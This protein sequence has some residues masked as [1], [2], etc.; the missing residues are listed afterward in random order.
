MRPVLIKRILWMVPTILC[1]SI[2]SFAL[3]RIGGDPIDAYIGEET[4]PAAIE[5]IVEQYHFDAPLPVQYWY[6]FT[7][8]LQ[9]DWG[10]SRSTGGLPVL[11]AIAAYLPASVELAAFSML[12][13][14]AL[15]LPLGIVSATRSNGLIDNLSRV[16]S[17]AGVATPTF[18]F[19]LLLQFFLFY[20]L[21]MAGLPHLPLAGRVGMAVSLAHPLQHITGLYLLDSLLTGNWVFFRSAFMHL[22]LPSVT[23]GFMLMGVFTRLT[24]SS[25]LDVLRVDYVQVAR[26]KGLP[27]R[28]VIVRHAL[29]NALIPLVTVF[30]LR[31]GWVLSG[32][33]LVEMVFAF[34]GLGYWAIGGIQASDSATIMG[35]VLIV[36]LIRSTLNLLTDMAYIALDPRIRY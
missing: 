17:L 2:L 28:T 29:R 22:I 12:I 34:P 19:A 35:F 33:I 27:E 25:M 32:A 13:A 11:S 18:W 31:L 8:L 5:R 24:R 4:P 20:K 7:G 9:G 14:L 26:A 23:L 21:K 3:S 6:Y 10:I 36:A 1:V 15:S 16:V 30:G